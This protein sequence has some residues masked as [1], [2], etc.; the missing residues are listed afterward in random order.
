MGNSLTLEQLARYTG[1]PEERLRHWQELG[2]LGRGVD[3]PF[4]PDD[5]ERARLVQLLLRR[6]IQLE[7]IAERRRAGFLDWF[8][9]FP[10][11]EAAGRV[12]S[13]PE[14]AVIVGM[15]PETLQQFRDSIGSM[16]PED[17]ISEQELGLLRGWKVASDAGVP[18]DA[19][20]ELIR[21]YT[22]SLERVAEAEQRLYRFYVYRRLEAEGLSPKELIERAREATEQLNPIVEPVLLYFHRRGMMKAVREDMV[23]ELAELQGLAPRA[24]TLADIQ[25]AVVFTDVSSFT[26]LAEAMGDVAAAHI[27]ERFAAIVRGSTVAWA[28]RVVKQIGDAFML[29]FPEARSAVACA[30]EIEARAAKEPQFPAVRAGITG[31]P[32]CTARGTTLVRT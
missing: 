17:F 10:F 3:G 11:R 8:D 19:I 26:P 18:N 20:A 6:G 32:C 31:E 23:M 7:A 16:A 14:A 4:D 15:E 2:I 5:V 21:V 13:L 24:E 30:L 28:G 1:E 9:S 12:Y 29:V 25:M 27:L 22:D